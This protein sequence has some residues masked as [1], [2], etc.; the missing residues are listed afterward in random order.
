MLPLI[1]SSWRNYFENRNLP[2]IIIQLPGHDKQTWPMMRNVQR[3]IA[4]ITPNT[5]LV[6]T[7]DL[8]NKTNIHPKDKKTVGERVSFV[9]LNDSYNIDSP[10]FPTLKKHVLKQNKIILQLENID[11]QLISKNQIISGFE[12]AG[13]DGEYKKVTAKIIDKNSIEI[14]SKIHN[15]QYLRYLWEAFPEPTI[16]NS[17]DLPLGP[18]LIKLQ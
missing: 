2:F 8:G 14:N 6:T 11:E 9:A 5:S 3:D 1:I 13:D 17:N 4:Q 16:F 7:I 10:K 12:I 18:F 15:P